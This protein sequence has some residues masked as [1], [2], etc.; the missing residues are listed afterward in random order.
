M[1]RCERRRM[2]A[3][4]YG[5]V[6]LLLAALASVVRHRVRPESVPKYRAVEYA[7]GVVSLYRDGKLSALTNLPLRIMPFVKKRSRRKGLS[8]R[9][10]CMD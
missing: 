10:N 1:G 5:V 7:A 4:S 2:T 3:R 9:R 6:L 8:G